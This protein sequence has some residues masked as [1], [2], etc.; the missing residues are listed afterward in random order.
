MT[1]LYIRIGTRRDA[2][3]I[4]INGTDDGDADSLLGQALGIDAKPAKP[5]TPKVIVDLTETTPYEAGPGLEQALAKAPAAYQAVQAKI[6]FICLERRFREAFAKLPPWMVHG[7]LKGALASFKEKDVDLASYQAPA[8][9][10]SLSM[11]VTRRKDHAVVTL[12]G[13]DDLPNHRDIQEA[14][15]KPP[16]KRVVV[17]LGRMI[18]RP[19]EAAGVEAYLVDLPEAYDDRAQ[20]RFVCTH[21]RLL[22]FFDVREMPKSF[23]HPDVDAALASFVAGEAEAELNARTAELEAESREL[24]ARSAALEREYKNPA[25]LKLPKIGAAGW[26][27]AV[28]KKIGPILENRGAIRRV[29]QEVLAEP[30]AIV[31]KDW[32]QLVKAVVDASTT[33]GDVSEKMYGERLKISQI[34]DDEGD[35]LEYVADEHLYTWDWVL[36][37]LATPSA[38]A[39]AKWV[40]LV[41]YL[42]EAK[43]KA[44]GYITYAPDELQAFLDAAAAHP[45]FPQARRALRKAFPNAINW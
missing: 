20:I 41:E 15:D 1:S 25:P 36:D 28:K 27:A 40:E 43:R 22:K 33:F 5:P 30:R 12:S 14:L 4:S 6:R 7:E 34:D 45:K 21:P 23:I 44:V 18:P 9:T 11:T 2:T 29:C 37:V 13:V 16:R 39:H 10:P 19:G 38:Q 24:E 8:L 42:A 31:H 32:P 35:A 26:T 3:F 17:D